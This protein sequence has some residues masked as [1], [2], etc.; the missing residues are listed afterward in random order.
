MTRK[1]LLFLF[2]LPYLFLF[3]ACASLL[4]RTTIA[5]C[6]T[7]STAGSY[8]LTNSISA[9]GD[10]LV[11]EAHHVTIDLND[12]TLIGS[13]TGA[14]ITTRDEILKDIVVRNGNI[15]SFENG[16]VMLHVRDAIIENIRATENTR[17]GIRIGLAG[18]VNPRAILK[19]NIALENGVTDISAGSGVFTGNIAD[20][21]T[22]SNSV[23]IGNNFTNLDIDH[24]YALYNFGSRLL[25]G[26]CPAVLF[27]NVYGH[28]L[29]LD[30]P[31]VFAADCTLI[32]N[33]PNGLTP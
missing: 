13:G 25:V 7:I 32:H 5:E 2:F 29:S 9:S 30:P 27:G 26:N 11:I 31:G 16:I 14:G 24:G 17:T 28:L 21:A 19:N 1:S 10:C 20:S 12:F 6:T 3:S 8:I 33:V 18:P 23:N 15:R 4:G 22:A